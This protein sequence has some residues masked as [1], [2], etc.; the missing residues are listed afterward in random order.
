MSKKTKK[1]TGL[2]TLG[3]TFDGLTIS[4]KHVAALATSPLKPDQMTGALH[5]PLPTPSALHQA[6]RTLFQIISEIAFSPV[7]K[8]SNWWMRKTRRFKD[9]HG[10]LTRFVEERILEWRIQEEKLGGDGNGEKIEKVK[11][12]VR[13]GD[14]DED[15]EKD[16]VGHAECVLDMILEREKKENVEK[17]ERNELRD[18]MMTYIM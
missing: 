16:W 15:G 5:L 9:A 17:M 13:A 18:E 7:P 2:I 6:I 8:V 11:V 12:D 10:F 3:K 14:G 4:Q 1:N